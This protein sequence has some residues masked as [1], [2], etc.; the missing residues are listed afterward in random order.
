MR[1]LMIASLVVAVGGV[2]WAQP[3]QTAPALVGATE[4]AKFSASV[5]FVDDP[6]TTDDTRIAY[7]VADASK[8]SELHVQTMGGAEQVVDI[9]GVTLHPIAL[10]LV[11]Q[12]AF[13]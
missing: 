7:V 6:V 12:R 1:G 13:V 5:G 10:R 3:K 11:G 2:A 8:K 9:A 4:A